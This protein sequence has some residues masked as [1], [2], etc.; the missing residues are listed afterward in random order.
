MAEN[1]DGETFKS[2]IMG[3]LNRLSELTSVQEPFDYHLDM[4]WAL[5]DAYVTDEDHDEW[6][7][8]TQ[9]F[10]YGSSMNKLRIISMILYRAGVL[11]KRNIRNRQFKVVQKE[12][13]INLKKGMTSH[14]KEDLQITQFIFRHMHLLSFLTKRRMNATIHIDVMWFILSPYV[15]EED[16]YKW[17]SNNNTFG[18]PDSSRY[19][20]YRWNIEKVRIIQM[21]MHRAD[22]LWKTTVVDA[23]EEFVNMEGEINVRSSIREQKNCS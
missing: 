1:F 10:S 14:I 12:N 18:N 20:G 23:P 2:V 19:N 9:D 22:F 3:Y 8:Q 11:P 15:T 7:R 6:E 17:E 16:Y 5:L 4:M 21:V 13:R